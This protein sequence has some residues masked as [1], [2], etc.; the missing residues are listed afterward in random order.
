MLSDFGDYHAEY[1][2]D[3]SLIDKYK[4]GRKEFSVFEI[5]PMR[6]V[7]SGLKIQISVS[8]VSSRKGRL[9][10]AFSDWSD[11]EFRYDCEKQAFAISA[12]K[13]GGI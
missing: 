2:D 11:V 10:L 13:L 6:N 3:Q 5:H 8:W 7:G 9:V 12:V 4:S 1:L